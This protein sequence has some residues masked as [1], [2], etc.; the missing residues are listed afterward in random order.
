MKELER[1]SIMIDLVL[2]KLNSR[3]AAINSRIDN[4]IDKMDENNKELVRRINERCC[5]Q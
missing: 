1:L 3:D 4:L 5:I 2:S